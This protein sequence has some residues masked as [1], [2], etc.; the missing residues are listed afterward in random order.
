MVLVQGLAAAILNWYAMQYLNFSYKI[1]ATPEDFGEIEGK[2]FVE[3]RHSST[4]KEKKK[5]W[6]SQRGS[7][8]QLCHLPA[9]DPVQ[10]KQAFTRKRRW[11]RCSTY[12]RCL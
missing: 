5:R 12:H 2:Y 11:L 8:W 4:H 10:T 7:E 3:I 6:L 1:K 9:G